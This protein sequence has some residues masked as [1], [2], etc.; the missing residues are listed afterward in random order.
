[1]TRCFKFKLCF[2]FYRTD[3]FKNVKPVIDTSTAEGKHA[4]AEAYSRKSNVIGRNMVDMYTRMDN[5]SV[6]MTF[7]PEKKSF[8]IQ[9][10]S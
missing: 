10:S 3:R 7:N 8:Q 9:F 2:I 1:M 6:L 4:A 5:P